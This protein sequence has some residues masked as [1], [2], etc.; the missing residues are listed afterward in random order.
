MKYKNIFTEGKIGE[1]TLKNR[2]IMS[3]MSPGLAKRDGSLTQELIDFYEER[4]KSDV[5][6]II[7]GATKINEENGTME[8]YQL[9]VT[10]DSQIEPL[11]KFSETMHKHGAK[12][13]VQLGHPGRQTF[14][15]INEGGVVGPSPIPCI[16]CREDTRELSTEEVKGLVKDFVKGAVRLKAA[17]IDGVELHAAH[18]YLINQF[19][20]PYSNKRTDEYGGSFENRI[21]FLAEIIEGIRR[22]CGKDYPISVRVSV[23]EFLKPFGINE[24]G[25]ELEE[26]IK[27]VKYLEE[28]GIDAIN[29]SSGVYITSHTIIEPTSYAQGWRK[30]LAQTI[31]S[32]VKIPVIAA[33][34][35][36]EPE[37]VEQLLEDQ[38]T[39]FVAIGRGLVADPEWVV[40]AKEDRTDD[41]RK[42]I[43][44]LTCI[45]NVASHSTIKCCLNAEAGKESKIKKI[46]KNGDGR[47]VVVLGA[48]PSGMEAARVLAIRGFKVIIFEKEKEVGGQLQ[49][50][51]KPPK[52]D[53]ITWFIDYELAQLRKLGVEIILDKEATIDMIKELNPYAVF[54]AKG[55]SSIVPPIDG[56]KGENVYLA[57]DILSGKVKLEGK[58][59]AVIGSGMTGLETSELL[60]EQG[61]QVSIVE[62]LD[63]IGYG[64]YAPNRMD[65]LG[66][67]MKYKAE[68]LPAHKLEKIS[69]DR[70]V[71]ENL[72]TKEVIEKEIDNIVLSI[73]V[74]PNNQM[75][76]E[77][78]NNFEN[79]IVIGDANKT[80]RI[81]QAV[82]DGYMEAINL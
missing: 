33:G 82:E 72:K 79:I 14:A 46:D 49:L 24:E 2:I 44:C 6:L 76:E 27:I 80:G 56:V 30:H 55:S 45:E 41:I 60:A 54:V 34:V 3:P 22:E 77:L 1:L 39:D 74:K 64:I 5:G 59:V 9:A 12:V 75:V 35:L 50:A 10:N 11:K 65:V 58:K 43:S 48:G 26:G 31:K 73:G 62:M 67:L 61:N 36:R 25:I 40:K 16:V 7:V 42:C 69:L 13:F 38:V 71:L 17:N 29:V 57:S 78:K 28:F 63:R 52:K 81:V 18:G 53:K 66:R 32:T 68:M 8:P 4:A 15:N 51:N 37:L 47:V 19:L 70:I 21:R 23:D 20:S